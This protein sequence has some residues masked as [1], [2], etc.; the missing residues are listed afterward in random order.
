MTAPTALIFGISGQTGAY[1]AHLLLHKGY[2]VMGTSRDAATNGFANLVRL[3][4]RD[5]IQ[6]QSLSLSNFN[7]TFAA[8]KAIA[9][10]Q[11]YNL[12]GQS[13]VALS[14][15]QPLQTFESVSLA[16]LNI[17]E[18]LRLYG[19]PARFF[20]STSSDSFGYTAVAANEGTAFRPQSPY[21]TAKATSFWSVV[22]YRNAY[23]LHACNGILSNH[24]SPLRPNR[25][26]TRKVI[27]AAHRIADGSKERLSMGDL[28]VERD[29]GWAPDYAEAMWR[30]VRH[31]TASDFVVATGKISSLRNFVDEAFRQ[32]GLDWRDHVDVDV[33]LFRPSEIQRVQL[34]PSRIAATLGWRAHIAMPELVKVLVES[35]RCGGLGPLPWQDNAIA[36]LAPIAGRP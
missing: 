3:G 32:F 33:R 18:S 15:E 13:S 1:L 16:T 29:W 19:L 6:L 17:L 23:G 7:D 5:R 27:L 26:V 34:D 9:P 24:E 30:I 12:G 36:G 4:I 11:I 20:N 35:E 25:F 21:A 22:T 10:D 31:N 2:R 28:K 14:F 8:I